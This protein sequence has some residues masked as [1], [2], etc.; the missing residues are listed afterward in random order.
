M[1][2]LAIAMI[3]G[4]CAREVA[5]DQVEIVGNDRVSR[6]HLLASARREL[7]SWRKHHR[8]ADLADAAYAMQSLLRDRGHAKAEVESSEVADGALFTVNEGPRVHI[9]AVRFPGALHASRARRKQMTEFFVAGSG[10]L[11]I[12]RKAYSAKSVDDAAHKVERLYLLAGHLHVRAGPVQERWNAT[13]D[14]VDLIVPVAEG[15]RYTVTSV[16][17]RIPDGTGVD[18]EAAAREVSLAGKPF[19]PRLPEQAA[20]RLRG[21]L[22]DLG[23]IEGD[24]RAEITIDEQSHGVGIVFVLTPGPVTRL[25]RITVDGQRRTHKSFIADRFDLDPGDPLGQKRIDAGLRDLY[26]SGLFRDA[27]AQPVPVAGAPGTADLAVRVDEKLNRRVDTEIGWGSY[28]ML[29]AKIGYANDNILGYGRHYDV[30][31]RASMR[32]WGVGGSL[33]D[34]YSFGRRKVVS[35]A[36]DHEVR[37]EPSFDLRS[38]SATLALD[39]R[40]SEGQRVRWNLRVGEEI[41]FSEATNIRGAIPEAEAVGL[42]TTSSLFAVLSRDS[43]DDIID[44]STGSRSEVS[45]S[46]SAPWL[47]AERE[48]VEYACRWARYLRLD[49]RIVLAVGGRFTTRDVLDGGATLPIQERLFLGGADSVRSFGQSELGPSAGGDPLGGLTSAMA[50][51]ELRVRLVAALEG[52]SFVDVGSVSERTWD[53]AWPLGTAIGGGLRYVLPVGPI[54]VD[55][56]WNP[57]DR[58]AAERNWAVHAAVG[59]SF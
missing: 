49:P 3:V 9:D 12:G 21:W 8:S 33:A 34:A 27:D 52:A 54:R 48:F 26:R 25:R 56:A 2:I 36:L 5:K 7:D 31:V 39:W 28:E 13:G 18:A 17:V 53:I 15:P 40:I 19:H 22:R 10:F 59:F 1:W 35:L 20:A 37:E 29:R 38:D 43:R 44:P 11:G 50:S 4:G 45:S 46:Y 23:R 42:L 24:A 32:G 16:E 30:G 55:A 58:F 51:V 6:T 57:G 41:R 47:G 14:E